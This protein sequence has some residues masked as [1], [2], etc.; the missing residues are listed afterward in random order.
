V[1]AFGYDIQ[2]AQS[3]LMVLFHSFA[4]LCNVALRTRKSLEEDAA[5]A[6]AAIAIGSSLVI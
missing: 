1:Y 6:P 2:I 4:Q 3:H 5:T